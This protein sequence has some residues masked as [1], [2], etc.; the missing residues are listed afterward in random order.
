MKQTLLKIAKF[1]LIGASTVLAILLTFGIVLIVGWAWWV[2]FFVFAVLVGLGLGVLFVR[3]IWIRH[4]EEDFVGQVIAQDDL[5]LKAS[6]DKEREACQEMQDRWKEAI[7]ALRS[8]HL[9]KKG[10]PLYV[11][12]WYLVIGE[13]G[14][15]KSTAIKSARLS[16]PFAEVSST[17]GISGTRN[18][19]WWFFEQAIIIDTAGRYTIPIDEGRDKDEWRR[20]LSLLVKFRKK[21]P[22]NGLVVT[23]AAE[24]VL[25]ATPEAME[26]DG[27]NVRRRINELMQ[28]L[29]AKF[30]VYVLVT[31]CDLI[32]GMTQFCNQLP[33]EV[34]DQAMGLINKDL[35]GDAMSFQS[36]VIHMVGERLRDLRLHL[37]L[38]LDQPGRKKSIDPELVLFPEEFEKV[39]SGLDAFVK[40]AFGKNPYQETPILRGVFFSSG[41][42]EGRPFSHFLKALGLLGERDILPGTSKGLFLHDF[43]SRILPRDRTLF[44]PTQG[45]IHWNQ[46]T[47]N[48]G[49]MS[50]VAII[51]GLC[52]LLSFS[53][54]KNLKTLKAISDEFSTPI[55]IQGEIVTDVGVM[56]RF[57]QAIITVEDLNRGW[58][59][60]RFGLDD[61]IEVER[62]LKERYCKLFSERFLIPF[63]KQIET[64]ISGFSSLIDDRELCI[65]A[66][67][68]V[69]RINL[70]QS[71]LQS[72]DYE[73][74][75][76][77]PQPFSDAASLAAD[78]QAIPEVMKLIGDQYLCYLLWNEDP[79]GLTIE[80]TTLQTYLKHI[81]TFQGSNLNWLVFWA[82]L[83]PA[84]AGVGLR[85]FWGDHASVPQGT[86]VPAA[87]TIAGKE[88]I[89]SFLKEMDTAL[90]DPLI[91]SN[92]KLEFQQWY[93]KEYLRSWHAFGI[94]FT[95]GAEGLNSR[96]QMQ[97]VIGRMGTDRCPFF[98]FLSRMAK[99][100]IHL[101]TGGETPHWVTLV[102]Q[103]E[104][105]RLGATGMAALGTAEKGGG[106]TA[107]AKEAFSKIERKVDALHGT[108]LF[109]AKA[110][111]AKAFRD[112]QTALAAITPACESRATAYQIAA[113]TFQEDQTEGDSPFFKAR[114]TVDRLKS[115]LGGFDPSD[116]MVW[117][118]ITGPID[119]L[120]KFVSKETAC[121]MQKKWE[122]EVLVEI[123]GISDQ[124]R[125][126]QILFG[127]DGCAIKFL[128]GPAA[129]FINR[130][131]AQGFSA[132]TVLGE[133]IPFESTF[134]HLVT[135][136]AN[137][138]NV[139][140]KDNYT[141]SIAG[142]PTDTEFDSSYTGPLMRVDTTKLELQ[143]ADEATTLINRN[144]P[145]QKAFN[146]S[147]ENCGEVS[148]T[149]Q[150]R[151]IVLTRHYTGEQGFPKF[152]RDFSTGQRV[153][154]P[155]DFPDQK[156]LLQ[157][158]G[159]KYIRVRY[160]IKGH[161][162]V[163]ALLGQNLGNAPRT[164]VQCWAQ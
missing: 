1:F 150:I 87:F 20:F 70:I 40:G 138:K 6:A 74:L 22:I 107:K 84:L 97:Q 54:A 82:N 47:R 156:A 45:A 162:P 122:D 8:S 49:L 13:S 139:A 56:D 86:A 99:E 57:R 46:L 64:R 142:K 104:A 12:P 148:L 69:R 25:Q 72:R 112:Y 16:S 136:G 58:W 75:A 147:P 34:L 21:E 80:K 125:S 65:D 53:F 66:A 35:S 121:Y 11:L 119:S 131:L 59:M 88:K 89:E 26:E 23:V 95:T 128:K 103:L 98:S 31:K 154:H 137:L 134:L 108:D 135:R 163:I 17:S 164:I 130:S 32:Q 81:L 55:K 50:W 27:R 18:C 68:L 129:P 60:P 33:E 109:E 92:K 133:S 61:S 52:G 14:T 160:D 37:F 115:D 38:K 3:K 120:W 116:E 2:G 93:K 90:P 24:K 42:Q 101:V 43:F 153:F 145:V 155:G 5:Y 140:P 149:I 114:N 141:V 15:G 30:P 105:A 63:D 143:C 91:I 10:N 71:R 158:M 106:V 41:R 77:L 19:D 73:K 4:R 110:D 124:Q 62:G 36:R 127:D 39:K 151:D 94:A 152:L 79:N 29:G 51:I 157:R 118:V 9:R 123:Q 161:Q 67:H 111:A 7:S 146:W 83:D 100:L 117:K 126:N 85:D 76:S 48:L 44:A 96:E 113:K 159:I 28:V 132:K 78:K 102:S 144:Y